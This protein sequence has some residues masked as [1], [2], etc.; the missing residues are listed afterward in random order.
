[1]RY[2]LSK[3][4]IKQIVDDQNI[5]LMGYELYKKSSVFI[6]DGLNRT[7]LRALVQDHGGYDVSM[8]FSKLGELLHYRCSCQK[9][10]LSKHMCEHCTAVLLEVTDQGDLLKRIDSEELPW[11]FSDDTIVEQ[12]EGGLETKDEGHYDSIEEA[13]VIVEDVKALKLIAA[14]NDVKKRVD[15]KPIRLK[16]YIEWLKC[17][18]FPV[19]LSL[20]VGMEQMYNIKD[21]PA[22]AEAFLTGVPIYYGKK[23]TLEPQ[24]HCISSQSLALFEF[25]QDLIGDQTLYKLDVQHK[26]KLRLSTYRFRQF[27]D[28]CTAAEI[29]V[30]DRETD[31]EIMISEELPDLLFKFDYLEDKLVV[32]TDFFDAYEFVDQ[33]SFFLRQ[34]TTQVFKIPYRLQKI[35]LLLNGYETMPQIPKVHSQSALDSMVPALRRIGQ[36]AFGDHLS[37]D[38]VD[39]KMEKQVYVDYKEKAVTIKPICVYGDIHYN[40]ISKRVETNPHQKLCLRDYENEIRFLECFER[41]KYLEVGDHFRII[42]EQHIYTFLSEELKSWIQN[43]DIA[44][45][46]TKR[47]KQKQVIEPTAI[48]Q[49]VRISEQLDYLEYNVELEGVS[50]EEFKRILKAYREKKQYYLLKS[51]AY[52][53]LEKLNL[54]FLDQTISHYGIKQ[55]AIGKPIVLPLSSSFYLHEHIE[56]KGKK[57]IDTFISH[58][59]SLQNEPLKLPE[60]LA[61]KLRPYQMR[62]VKWLSSLSKLN[63]GGILADDM[64][65]GKTV[66]VLAYLSDQK[67]ALKGKRVLIVAPTS[68]IYN[69]GHEIDKFASHLSYSVVMGTQEERRRT[70]EENATT[71]LITSYGS[72]RRDL[73]LYENERFFSLI[74]DEAQHIKNEGSIGAKVVKQLHADHRF[75]V[76]GTPIENNLGELWSIFDFILPKHLGSRSYFRQTFE[77]PILQEGDQDAKA[78]LHDLIK[79]FLLR[80]LKKEVLTELPEKFETDVYVGMN[81]EQQKLYMATLM[82]IRGELSEDFGNQNRMKMLAALTRLRQICCHPSAYLDDYHGGSGKL[83]ALVETLDLLEGSGRRILVFSQFTSVLKIIKQTIKQDYFYL[84]GKTAPKDRID[85]VDRFNAGERSVFLISLKAGGTGL[86]LTGADTVIHYDPW[87]NPA[88]EQQATDRAYR[89]GQ[90]KDVHVI[91]LITQDTIEEKIQELQSHKKQLIED[92][93]EPGETFISGLTEQEIKALFTA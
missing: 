20:R 93:I 39:L 83:D 3:P 14:F 81:E 79:P 68:L 37:E 58:V 70:V 22:F 33:E 45:Y 86:N 77:K 89:I 91:K 62:G 74:L 60:Q 55:S 26:Q 1:M 5:W 40:P 69:W 47:F 57:V 29:P 61:L 10:G 87:W 73:E 44:V 23:F 71:I 32:E 12:I 78:K 80:R 85:L 24:K 90:L 51:G 13:K 82:R 75:A 35:F 63:L 27:V 65:L 50:Q 25:I 19:A 36:V 11:P 21:V 49:E 15:M 7:T 18:Q 56:G 4:L 31:L 34:G 52:V 42:R 53:S 38:L 46:S 64:G 72:L 28:L 16:A 17:D 9:M 88:V 43:S 48:R 59:E 41:D 76:T 84:D 67:M 92:F 6:V 30:F 54:D 2:N 8:N 66:Q